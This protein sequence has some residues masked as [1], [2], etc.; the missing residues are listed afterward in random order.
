MKRF[1]LIL[2]VI[3]VITPLGSTPNDA[4]AGSE[5]VAEPTKLVAPENK[6]NTYIEKL[7]KLTA[8]KG[9]TG[10]SKPPLPLE[11][12]PMLPEAPSAAF[13]DNVT[14]QAYQQSLQAYYH[15]RQSGLQHRG[16]VFK[17]QLFSGKV[18]FIVVLILVFLG[19]YFAAVQF[20]K[21]MYE[22]AGDNER[23]GKE[24][25]TEFS[26][27]TE[28]IKV[29]SPVL[30]VIILVISLAFFYLYLTFVYPV[31]DIF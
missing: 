4:I 28:G 17:W 25:N 8:T 10:N 2:I 11:T 23:S 21:N 14:Q 7:K 27:S 30:G 31:E 5:A 6:T 22:P 3:L 20:H 15:Y 1:F 24:M 9:K 18:I 13:A 26:A 12:D 29:S 19:I 16:Q